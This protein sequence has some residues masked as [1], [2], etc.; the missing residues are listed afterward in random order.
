MTASITKRITTKVVITVLSATL[1]SAWTIIRASQTGYA[2]LDRLPWVPAALWRACQRV[3]TF[4]EYLEA[5]TER[6][7]DQLGNAIRTEILEHVL[8]RASKAA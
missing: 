6:A 7:A 5:F 3:R 4:G 8:A 2:A 1:D